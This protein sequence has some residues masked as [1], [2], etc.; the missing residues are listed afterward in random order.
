MKDIIVW[1]IHA[2]AG[3]LVFAIAAYAMFVKKG[4]AAHRKAGSYFTISMMVMLVSGIAAAYLKNS[5]GD[6]MLGA[7]VMYTVFTAWLAAH[8]K[9]NEAGLLEAT[10]LIWIV[11]LAITAFSLSMG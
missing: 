6:M 7:I 8:H 4:T 10:A 1:T 5:I 11:G 3:T 9:K 2:P